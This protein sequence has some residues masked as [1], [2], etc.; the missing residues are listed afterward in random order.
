MLSQSDLVITL[1]GDG[2]LLA[3]A[4]DLNGKPTPLLGVHLGNLGF[5]TEVPRETL[6]DF[7]EDV[8]KKK[9]RVERRAT[10]LAEV[11][12]GSESL[13]SFRALNEVV[14][15][16]GA[17]SRLM[18]LEVKVGKDHLANFV[19]DGLIL[20]TPTGSTGHSLSAGG[21][22][23]HPAVEAFVLTPICPHSLSSRPL[24]IPMDKELT[25]LVKSSH[26][27]MMLTADGQQGTRLLVGDAVHIKNSGRPVCLMLSQ[28]SSY[29][30]VLH[31]K[32]RWG[33]K[34]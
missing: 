9:Y 19:A 24:L 29:W 28:T 26:E 18:H 31:E 23:V 17:L 34:R 1:G 27:N 21:P 14:V 13:G 4:R 20:A 5:L 3:A 7:L 22:I 15:T 32:L 30:D 25:V 6:P 2:T 8:F 12:R 10:L 33:E 11:R 16:K